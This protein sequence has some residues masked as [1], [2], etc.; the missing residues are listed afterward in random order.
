LE[1]AFEELPRRLGVAQDGCQRLV[2]L[3]A[4]IDK[5]GLVP[6]NVLKVIPAA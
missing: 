6:T 3:A 1:E 4:A 2:Q 5:L